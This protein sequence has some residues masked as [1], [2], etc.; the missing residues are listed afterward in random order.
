M[1]NTENRQSQ[2]YQILNRVDK[3]WSLNYEDFTMVNDNFYND[4]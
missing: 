3:K 1:G 4:V 2:K